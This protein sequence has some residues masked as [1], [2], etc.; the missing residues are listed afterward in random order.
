MKEREARKERDLI[1]INC[2]SLPENLL[3][4]ELFG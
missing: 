2:A 4:A 1:V 3:E